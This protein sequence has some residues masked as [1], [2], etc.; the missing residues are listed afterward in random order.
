MLKFIILC[1]E[2]KY[3]CIKQVSAFDNNIYGVT[4]LRF[5]CKNLFFCIN[6]EYYEC[7]FKGMAKN[8]QND[9]ISVLYVALGTKITLYQRRK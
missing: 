8:L 6:L 5:R 3:H 1:Y 9:E 7:F 2:Y 4:F